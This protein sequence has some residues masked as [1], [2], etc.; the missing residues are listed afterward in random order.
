MSLI[1]T[2]KEQIINMAAASLQNKP[3]FSQADLDAI[4]YM[5]DMQAN[6]L[7]VESLPLTAPPDPMPTKAEILVKFGDVSENIRRRVVNG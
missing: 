5:I 3:T 7:V 1:E 2:T 6:T 4:D